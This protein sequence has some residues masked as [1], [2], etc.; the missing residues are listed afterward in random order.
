MSKNRVQVILELKDRLSSGLKKAR[1]AV[2]DTVGKVKGKLADLKESHQ[3]AFGAMKDQ[4]PGFAS[5]IEL[6]S[7]PY[8]LAAAA[9]V[10]LGLAVFKLGSHLSDLSK[11]VK[12]V[13][14]D[15]RATMGLTGDALKEATAN[16]QA[17]ENRYEVGRREIIDA[18]NA[19]VRELGV[20]HKEAFNL[21]ENAMIATN[22]A[23]DIDQVKEYSVQMKAVG[24][25]ADQTMGLLTKAFKEG[26]YQDKAIDS[27]KEANIRLQ[28]MPK[29]TAEAVTGLGLNVAKLQTGLKTGTLSTMDAVRMVSEQLGKVDKQV[30]QTAIANIFGAAGEDAG[31]TWLLGLSKAELSMSNMVD[32]QDPYIKKQK[33]RLG[34]EKQLSLKVQ[35]FSDDVNGLTSYFEVLGM[36][37][38]I[39]F[40]DTVGKAI[41]YI[42][43]NLFW[44]WDILKTNLMPAFIAIKVVLAGL[45]YTWDGILNAITLVSSAV[46]GLRRLFGWLG[47][48]VTEFFHWV[49]EVTGARSF[50][51]D[52]FG[53]DEKDSISN[54]IKELFDEVTIRF[55]A[56]S[57]VAQTAF[58][59]I[60]HA[61][62]GDFSEAKQSYNSIKSQLS[63]IFSE[64][65][66]QR[67]KAAMGVQE[68]IKKPA[69]A[70]TTKTAQYLS[71][72]TLPAGDGSTTSSSTSIGQGA[73]AARN[74]IINADMKQT[75]DINLYQDASQGRTAEDFMSEWQDM[76][77][78]TLNDYTRAY[79]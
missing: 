52:L 17:L 41:T 61:L 9:A 56:L 50:L 20:S 34:L 46:I 6:L 54:T 64:G 11:E 14:M 27:L 38:K 10:A 48:K 62:R 21:I 58:K 63:D 42:K 36:K 8:A 68:E 37:A 15:V 16:V 2:G 73:K 13:Q 53:L 25:N 4:I 67:R 71:T 5:A 26:V 78:R 24:L 74:I 60:N 66:V 59:G 45:K 40:Y 7:N 70:V 57:K 69:A 28:E 39:V 51:H 29:A 43:E 12:K 49:Y 77:A 44:V 19:M 32:L 22:G 76:I 47:K 79:G 30:Q 31:K 72:G 65:Y 55:E 75:G 1:S 23:L 33:E 3:K 35:A 18:G